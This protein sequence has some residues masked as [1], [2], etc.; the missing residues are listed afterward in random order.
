MSA[1]QGTNNNLSLHDVESYKNSELMQKKKKMMQDILL[2]MGFNGGKG[3]P[4]I[5][6]S[7]DGYKMVVKRD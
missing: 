7:E 1:M 3:F 5:K 4:E 2:G 6:W